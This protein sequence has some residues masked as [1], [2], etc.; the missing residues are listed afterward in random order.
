[1]QDDGVPLKYCGGSKQEVC[2][3]CYAVY[4]ITMVN[5][6]EEMNGKEIGVNGSGSIMSKD[7]PPN[8][9]SDRK[10]KISNHSYTI[11]IE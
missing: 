10:S 2:R 9:E 1:M 4:K 3:N 5:R 11:V 8:D 6:D 7:E